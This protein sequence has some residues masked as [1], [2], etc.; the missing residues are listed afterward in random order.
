MSVPFTMMMIIALLSRGG[1]ARDCKQ[2]FLSSTWCPFLSQHRTRLLRMGQISLMVW[3]KRVTRSDFGKRSILPAATF[4]ISSREIVPL[5]K[6]RFSC[7]LCKRVGKA[8]AEV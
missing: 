3:K 2:R 7:E 4:D 5:K 6:Q 1:H 8:V